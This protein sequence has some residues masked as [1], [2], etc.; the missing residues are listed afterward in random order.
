EIDFRRDRPV[1]SQSSIKLRADSGGLS[2]LSG[3][4]RPALIEGQLPCATL[5]WQRVA[6]PIAL[7]ASQPVGIERHKA[8]GK[9]VLAYSGGLD[10][11]VAIHWLKHRR[12]FRVSVL[13]VNLGYDRD[14]DVVGERALSAG[15]ETVHVVDVRRTFLKHYC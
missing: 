3:R 4:I 12:N 2:P 5:A 15:A 6:I 14:I 7:T 8:M 13:T 1:P 11:T 9:V 10:T